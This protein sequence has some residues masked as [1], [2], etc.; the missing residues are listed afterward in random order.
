MKVIIPA[1]F[2]L[3]AAVLAGIYKYKLLDLDVAI[4]NLK[5]LLKPV[6]TCRLE[7]VI[8]WTA[9][10]ISEY[11]ESIFDV[12]NDV[13]SRLNFTVLK[14]SD[15]NGTWDVLWSHEYIFDRFPNAIRFMKLKPHQ[16]VNHFPGL[17]FLTNKLHLSVSTTKTYVPSSFNF[18]T[19]KNEF[20]YYAKVFPETKFVQKS[21]DKGNVTVVPFEKIHFKM[22]SWR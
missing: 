7:K 9:T 10:T 5:N 19:L 17:T 22:G 12:I 3:L 14:E 11:D 8:V 6:S 18:P 16:L 4:N 20:L 13:S 2:A 15:E 21:M 1:F